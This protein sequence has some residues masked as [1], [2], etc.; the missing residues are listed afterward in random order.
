VVVEAD[1]IPID[2]QPAFIAAI[3]D[4]SPGDDI[5]IVVRRDDTNTSVVATLAER[6]A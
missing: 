6:P 2:G 1:G 5:E 4:K 3:R